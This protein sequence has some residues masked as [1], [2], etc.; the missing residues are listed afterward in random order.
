M[1]HALRQLEITHDLCLTHHNTNSTYAK[2]QTI[3]IKTSVEDFCNTRLI[4][5]HI[6]LY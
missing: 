6:I 2:M 4:N 3:I 1:S 5:K